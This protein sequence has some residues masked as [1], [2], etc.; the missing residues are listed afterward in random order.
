MCRDG[1]TYCI[2]YSRANTGADCNTDSVTDSVTDS[3][4]FS[5]SD[6]DTHTGTYRCTNAIAVTGTDFAS[7]CYANAFAVGC[8]IANAELL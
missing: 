4:S 5:F 1:G 2:S 8:S 6:S 3:I 7:V